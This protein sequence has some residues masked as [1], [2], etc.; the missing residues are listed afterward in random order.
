MLMPGPST[1]DTPSAC[2]SA[3]IAAPTCSARSGSHDEP[4]ATAGGKQ[5][6]GTLSAIPRWS[7]SAFCNRS[8][9]GPSVINNGGRPSRSTGTVV[10]KSRPL[11]SAAFSS[12]VS[13]ATI[14]AAVPSSAVG[15][16]VW[17]ISAFSLLSMVASS[18]PFEHR[19]AG[20]GL[21]AKTLR[22][23]VL[24]SKPRSVYS[25]GMA[26]R[27]S[28]AKGVAKR[29]EILS[30]ALVVIAREGYRNTSVRDLA[31]AVGLSQAGLLHYF[32]S[33]E[34]LF[35]EV[36]RKRDAVDHAAMQDSGLGPVDALVKVMRHNATVPGLVHL[37]DQLSAEAADPDHPAHTF[38]VERYATLHGHLTRAI[39]QA[40][41][42][43]AVPPSLDADTAATVM[44]AAADGLQTQWLLDPA[45][46]MAGHLAV[47]WSWFTS[48]SPAT[49]S[50]AA[51]AGRS[52]RRP[53]PGAR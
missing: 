35:T 9:C 26:P 12:S 24:K 19:A 22:C 44:V 34:E 25:R 1:T 52:G 42:D 39:E 43:G 3:A 8:P 47:L 21:R 4:S 16:L 30:T 33:K 49:P 36:L 28:Y 31:E 17:V 13:S 5:V 20:P 37:Y 50:P 32:S 48:R 14:S 40:Q 53:A 11:L 7:A 38:F 6:A 29:E 51:G 45:V 46:D 27:G 10:Q 2:A 18:R 23:S 41:S 15:V